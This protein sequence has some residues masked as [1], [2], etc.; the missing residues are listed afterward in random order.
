MPKSSNQKL[1]L[2]YLQRY[3]ERHS[4]EKH[5]VRIQDMQAE[6]ARYDITAERKS[7]YSDVE[8]LRMAGAEIIQENGGYYLADR[9]FELAELKLLVDSVQA[10]RFITKKKSGELIKKLEGLTSEGEAS[11]LERQVHVLNRVKT[12]NESI[13]YNVDSLHS[14][15]AGGKQILFRYFDYGV[16]KEKV[17]RRGGG[18]Y[19]ASPLALT[20]AEE[21]YYLVAY[22]GEHKELRHYR[23]DKMSKIRQ[24]EDPV[25]GQEQF[26]AEDIAR[27]ATRVF[28]MFRGQERELRLRFSRHLAGAVL[29]RFGRDVILVPQGEEHFTCT[30]TVAV[31]P[32]FYGW[33]CGFE[34]EAVILS[35]ADAAEDFRAYLRR[36]AASC[37]AAAGEDAQ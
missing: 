14:A 18:D 20:W 5:P 22:D 30:V 4:D 12:M 29:D 21:N 2:L 26:R 32:Q 35:P 25:L 7:L 34:G 28:G 15:I 16:D 23:V 17:Y 33:L 11:Q 9:R 13:Y 6:L 10:S 19:R 3:L 24:T 1:K 37:D 8:A 27:Y 36:L 31:S